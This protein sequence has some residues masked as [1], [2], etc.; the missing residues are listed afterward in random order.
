MDLFDL[1]NKVIAITGGYGYLGRTISR[2]LAE[3]GAMVYVLGR[4]KEKFKAA[5]PESTKNI[6][7]IVCDT[8]DTP[9]VK[10]AF[11]AIDKKEKRIDVLINNAFSVKGQH[12]LEI[13]DQE[14]RDS[15]EGTLN[16]F[17]RCIRE[18]VPYFKNNKAGKI[19]N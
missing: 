1:K 11:K 5:F 18:M 3:Y 2:G 7:F 10:A 14:W 15:L 6:K 19:I 9:S 8:G 13:S 4:S 12:P 17:Y 16:S